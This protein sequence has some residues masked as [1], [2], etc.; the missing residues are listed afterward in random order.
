MSQRPRLGATSLTNFYPRTVVH[1]AQLLV[2]AVQLHR[3]FV[4]MKLQEYVPTHCYPA[5]TD[6]CI[7]AATPNTGMSWARIECQDCG[8]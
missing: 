3:T 4:A 2:A 7:G 5:E 1:T 6:A 8:L